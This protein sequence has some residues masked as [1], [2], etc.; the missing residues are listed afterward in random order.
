VANSG[1]DSIGIFLGYGNA[2]FAYQ[3]IYSTGLGSHPY[4]VAVEYFNDDTLVDIVVANYGTNSVGVFL[5]HGNGTFASPI[6]T[7]LG[8]SHPLSIAVEDFNKDNHLDIAVANYGTLTVAILLGFNN[9]SFRINAIYDMG[10]D[11]IPYSLVIADFNYMTIISI[12]VLL[13][14]VR[15]N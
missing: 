11:S 14:M 1:T 2:T 13:I 15:A 10:Y 4:S 9:G 6:L 12:L 5:A 8:S 7:S 3:I